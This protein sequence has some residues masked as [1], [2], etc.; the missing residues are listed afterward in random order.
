MVTVAYGEKLYV[1]TTWEAYDSAT[2]S[3]YLVTGSILYES[4]SPIMYMSGVTAL[5]GTIIQGGYMYIYDGGM[6]TNTTVN[7]GGYEYVYSGGVVSG[8]SVASGGTIEG[9][10]LSNSAVDASQ[11]VY[12]IDG[13]TIQSGAVVGLEVELEASTSGFNI[14][15]GGYEDIYSGGVASGTTVNSAGLEYVYSGGVTNNT[16]VNGGLESI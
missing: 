13:I 7:S 10:V 9:L 5:D 6:A 16:T 2:K 1:D 4:N 8:G 3:Y 14:S 15:R 11:A 12:V